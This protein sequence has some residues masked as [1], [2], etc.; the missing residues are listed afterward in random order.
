M[1]YFYKFRYVF[2]L[3]GNGLCYLLC[4]D[5]YYG[6]IDKVIVFFVFGRKCDVIG[7]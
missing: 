3:N 4:N 6:F 5:L 2:F 7:V 1:E